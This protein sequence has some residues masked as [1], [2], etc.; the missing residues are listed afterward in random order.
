MTGANRVWIGSGGGAR[1][2]AQLVDRVFAFH[3]IFRPELA[4]DAAFRKGIV[5]AT[6]RILA[7]DAANFFRQQPASCH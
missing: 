6:T 2:A 3:A 4:L 5:A 1:V 7:R